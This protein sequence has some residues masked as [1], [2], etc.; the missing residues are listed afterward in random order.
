MTQFLKIRIINFD[1]KLKDESPN[2]NL[3]FFRTFKVNITAGQENLPL[4]PE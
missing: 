3:T 2:V 1:Q 4:K